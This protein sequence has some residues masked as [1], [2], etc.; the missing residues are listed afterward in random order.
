MTS[1]TVIIRNLGLKE[2]L[3]T[4]NKMREF[5]HNRDSNTID[6]CWLVEHFPVYTQGQAGKPEHIRDPGAIPVVQSDRGGQVTYHGPGQVI[7]YLLLDL[8]RNQCGVKKLIEAMEQAIIQL[9]G[10]Y[11]ITGSTQSKAPGVYVTQ[12]K[13][14]SLGL[15]VRR[16]CSYHG[17]SLNV[18]MDLAP[19]QNINPCG[20]PNL[21]VVQMLDFVPSIQTAAVGSRLVAHLT[22]L[23]GYTVLI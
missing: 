4:W 23:L 11:Q 12:H 16:G 9:L 3:E 22:Q 13:I 7:I 1:K 18:A 2:Y 15:R 21:K 5:T 6:E 17:L 14:A 20:Y 19:F 10:T 8:K